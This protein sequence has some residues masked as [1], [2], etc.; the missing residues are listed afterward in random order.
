MI[1]IVFPW[2]EAAKM[3]QTDYKLVQKYFVVVNDSYFDSIAS[4]AVTLFFTM[5]N[6]KVTLLTFIF[7]RKYVN[8]I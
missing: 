5:H 1:L 8:L 3:S 6:L 4:V 2:N 7:P